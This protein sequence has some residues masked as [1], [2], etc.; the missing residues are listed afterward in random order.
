MAR[1]HLPL[2]CSRAATIRLLHFTTS[3]RH[4]TSSATTTTTATLPACHPATPDIFQESPPPHLRHFVGHGHN[5]TDVP[6]PHCHPSRM[7]WHRWRSGL[8]RRWTRRMCCLR[9]TSG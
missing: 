3:S 2:S 9:R 1:R 6:M 7:W 4:T 8:A 5:G